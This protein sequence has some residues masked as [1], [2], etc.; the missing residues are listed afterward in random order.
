MAYEIVSGVPATI[1]GNNVPRIREA[2]GLG[3]APPTCPPFKFAFDNNCPFTFLEYAG[4]REVGLCPGFWTLKPEWQEG[5]I[6]HKM[7]H[8]CFGLTCAWFQHDRKERKRN[9]AYCYEAFALSVAG[10][11]PDPISIAKCSNTPA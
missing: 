10:Q 11:G 8:L 6:L 3:K 1:G 7:L 9:S 2:Q 4:R 5:T